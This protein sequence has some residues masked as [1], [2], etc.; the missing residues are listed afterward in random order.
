MLGLI[1]WLHL[2]F[3]RLMSRMQELH[4]SLNKAHEGTKYH[5]EDREGKE[6]QDCVNL[7]FSILS[8]V[9][10]TFFSTLQWELAAENMERKASRQDPAPASGVSAVK[11]ILDRTVIGGCFIS[12]TE[13]FQDRSP[14][15]QQAQLMLCLSEHVLCRG[16]AWYVI[17]HRKFGNYIIS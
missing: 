5:T 4:I 14:G 15:L 8:N 9:I 1:D 16:Q 17:C 11:T 12:I 2:F 6:K 3:S 10:R 13:C 7:A